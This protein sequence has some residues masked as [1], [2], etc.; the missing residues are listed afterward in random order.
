MPAAGCDRALVQF[1]DSAAAVVVGPYLAGHPTVRLAC[2]FAN[3]LVYADFPRRSIRF[4]QVS[5]ESGLVTNQVTLASGLARGTHF[6]GPGVGRFLV[7][8]RV[9]RM[10]SRAARRTVSVP[11]RSTESTRGSGSC[12]PNARVSGSRKPRLGSFSF[13]TSPGAAANLRSCVLVGNPT[14]GRAASREFFRDDAAGDRAS[15]P[16]RRLYLHRRFIDDLVV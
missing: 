11:H 14:I 1:H 3:G 13:C 5:A 10:S 4:A 2:P 12:G 16:G 15:E 8:H 7:P 6:F 9:C